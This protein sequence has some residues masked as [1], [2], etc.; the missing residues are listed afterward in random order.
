MK[1]KQ[2]FREKDSV[3][4]LGSAT[5]VVLTGPEPGFWRTLFLIPDICSG[6]HLKGQ[7]EVITRV[8]NP[9]LNR[10][11]PLTCT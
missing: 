7:V 11:I 1:I 2:L 8:E 9:Y 3:E 4:E 6:F 10:I 5:V